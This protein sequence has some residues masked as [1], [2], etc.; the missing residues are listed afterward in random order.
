MPD[1]KT[2]LEGYCLGMNSW[3]GNKWHSTLQVLHGLPKQ[4]WCGTLPHV[5]L[6]ASFA[7]V[8]R[9]FFDTIHLDCAWELVA[10][11]FRKQMVVSD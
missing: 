6:F 11:R 8:F 10:C 9:P 3:V 2:P 5:Q 1:A 4:L 7:Q